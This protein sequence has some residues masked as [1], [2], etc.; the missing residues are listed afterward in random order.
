MT[1]VLV[2]LL[3]LVPGVVGGSEESTTDALRAVADALDAGPVDGEDLGDPVDLHLAVL[4]Q[5]ADAHPDL[6]GR[7]TLHVLDQDGRDKRRRV[8]AEQIW[9]PATTR[10]IRADVVHHA[11]GVLPL[12]HPARTVL[13]V[14]DLQPLDMP[15][16]FRLS[17]RTYIRSMAGRSVRG[18]DVLTA[19]SDFTRDRLVA[20][21]DAAPERIEVVPWWVA[22]HTPIGG[23]PFPLPPGLGDD[24]FFLYPAITYPHKRHLV[25]LEAFALV[26][27]THPELRLVLTGGAAAAEAEV[28]T[29]MRR[30]DLDGRVLRPGRVPFEQLES[31]FAATTA[32]AVPSCYEGFGLPVLE[33]MVRGVPVLAAAAGSLPEVARPEDLVAAD[34]VEAWAAA[35]EAV[36]DETAEQR[37]ARIAAGH[38]RAARFTPER[39]AAGLL[40]A[41]RRARP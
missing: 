1:R 28:R 37:A 10:S 39:T 7:F 3:W 18:A 19:P 21:L 27:R 20:L 36:L 35:L 12:R 41:Y 17:K 23:D 25:L 4:E 33:A 2:N 30:P 31:L 29:R 16:N 9:L 24:P 8:L 6:A 32:V 40:R 14:H 13:T 11:G 26:A 22:P 15:A 34:D 38:E 5:F